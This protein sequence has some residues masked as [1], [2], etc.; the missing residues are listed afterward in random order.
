MQNSFTECCDVH[1]HLPLR[2]GAQQQAKHKWCLRCN[3]YGKWHLNKKWIK[4]RKRDFLINC[5]HY[6]SITV[7]LV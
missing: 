7:Q 3:Y 6:S 2:Q 1:F 5:M 4:D